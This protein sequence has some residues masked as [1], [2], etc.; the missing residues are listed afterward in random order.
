MSAKEVGMES[1]QF[2]VRSFGKERV[3]EVRERSVA[4][5]GDLERRASAREEYELKR[6]S[7]YYS[8]VRS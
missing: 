4:T 5:K 7:T 8:S 1:V 6:K 2:R 3:E